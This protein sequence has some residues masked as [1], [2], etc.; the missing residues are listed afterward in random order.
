VPGPGAG[1]EG[2]SRHMDVDGNACSAGGGS[3][4]VS[5]F[6]GMPCTQRP[7]AGPSLQTGDAAKEKLRIAEKKPLPRGKVGRV[8]GAVLD[9]AGHGSF[10]GLRR[11]KTGTHPGVQHRRSWHDVSSRQ[12]NLDSPKLRDRVRRRRGASK[13]CS[14]CHGAADPVETGSSL[15]IGERLADLPG[16]VSCQA[17][18]PCSRTK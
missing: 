13:R 3:G 1:L 9:H 5:A 4:I 10:A 12:R 11:M 18:D 6:R 17:I 8:S 15:S 14:H 2:P 7:T 16:P